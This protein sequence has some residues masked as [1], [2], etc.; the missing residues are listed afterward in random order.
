[1]SDYR[2]TIKRIFFTILM[3]LIFISVNLFCADR[4]DAGKKK[5]LLE[6]WD[7]TLKYGVSEQVLDVIKSIRDA[8]ETSLNEELQAVLSKSLDAEVRKGI[9]DYFIDTAF[10]GAEG[11]AIGKISTYE[12]EDKTYIIQLWK[13]LAAIGSAQ[14]SELAPKFIDLAD[15]GLAVAAIQAIGKLKDTSKGKLLLD[16]LL[17]D[18]YPQ[19]RKT[20]IVFSIGEMKLVDAVPSLIAIV[21][22]K[23]EE[24]GLR[25]F[26]CEALGKIKDKSSVDAL[27]K[28]F[29]ENNALLKVYAAAALSA[30]DMSEVVDL[31]IEGL[32][33]SNWKVRVESAKALAKKD[34]QAAIDILAWKVKNDTVKD[35][36][37]ESMRALS[38]I[39][40]NKSFD[41]LRSVMKS[42][43]ESSEIREVALELCINN[44]VG[45]TIDTIKLIV[46]AESA[47]PLTRQKFLETVAGK[48]VNVKSGGL[49]D[50]F[51]QF[52]D[53]QNLLIRAYGIRGAVTNNAGILRKKISD[54]A[55]N[56]P[57]PSVRREA[58][59]ALGK[60]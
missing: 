2:V 21:S 24:V 46:A 58:E 43:S 25:M 50:I 3:F 60:L 31:L 26:A 34:A 8:K 18:E 47:K 42:E 23:E 32:K 44:D 52:L 48:L 11:Y 4:D 37:K 12:D 28:V 40:T 13:Y 33:D 27:K 6:E 55:E 20:Q 39:G 5:S 10:K 36:R 17:D 1:M 59:S 14:V 41:L 19:I 56:D 49:L 45:A 35:V 16:K 30:F 54:L 29:T 53:S 7:T 9:V 22:D 15:D 57:S 38:V 51:S